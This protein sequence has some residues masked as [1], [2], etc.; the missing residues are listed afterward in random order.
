MDSSLSQSSTR[1]M[2]PVA[3]MDVTPRKATGCEPYVP[4]NSV[5]ALDKHEQTSDWARRPLTASQIED[6]ALDAEVLLQL[7]TI[8]EGRV[9]S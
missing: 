4:G 7:S 5:T 1:G 8:F 9:S 3:C 2:Y 6:A